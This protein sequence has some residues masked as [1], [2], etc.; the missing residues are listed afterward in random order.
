MVGFLGMFCAMLAFG[1]TSS[2][3]AMQADVQTFGRIDA[4]EAEGAVFP[5][6]RLAGVRRAQRC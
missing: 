3:E 6:D 2:V 1:G 5:V 4:V